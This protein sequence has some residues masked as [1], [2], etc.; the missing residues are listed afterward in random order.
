MR[1]TTTL[2][3]LLLTL[4]SSSS[5]STVSIPQNTQTPTASPPPT[6]DPDIVADGNI[7]RVEIT[8]GEDVSTLK[9]DKIRERIKQVYLVIPVNQKGVLECTSSSFK[10]K[11]LKWLKN[12]EEL[13]SSTEGYRLV[14]YEVDGKDTSNAGLYTCVTNSEAQTAVR[15]FIDESSDTVYPETKDVTTNRGESFELSLPLNV[16]PVNLLNFQMIFTA[17]P[18]KAA[19]Q[20]ASYPEQDLSDQVT[21]SDISNSLRFAISESQPQHHGM[22]KFIISYGDRTREHKFFLTVK[23]KPEIVS[24][25]RVPEFVSL[26]EDVILTVNVSGYPAPS[27]TWWHAPCCPQQQPV[28][29]KELIMEDPSELNYYHLLNDETLLNLK[30]GTRRFNGSYW[31]EAVNELGSIES[32]PTYYKLRGYNITV[33][34][35]N[36]KNVTSLVQYENVG[37]LS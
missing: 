4:S 34:S 10:D 6:T 27:I 14:E 21:I 32:S 11:T 22:Y 28:N 5:N 35:K 9:Q 24:F 30:G 31:F 33:D 25:Q 36:E 13:S 2:L 17:A 23:Y 37:S 19:V 15:V 29:I 26:Y 16:F 7:A 3:L 12:E 18:D 20:V 8:S 1:L